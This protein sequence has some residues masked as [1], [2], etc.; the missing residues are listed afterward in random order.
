MVCAR[1]LASAGNRR[2]DSMAIPGSGDGLLQHRHRRLLPRQR[3]PNVHELRNVD[4]RLTDHPVALEIDQGVPLPPLPRLGFVP[5]PEG[6]Q[7]RPKRLVPSRNTM[8]RRLDRLPGRTRTLDNQEV[9]IT[10]A[11]YPFADHLVFLV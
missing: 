5:L 7:C 11:A 9:P 2:A 6:V 10:T 3:P 8:P 1:V 4:D